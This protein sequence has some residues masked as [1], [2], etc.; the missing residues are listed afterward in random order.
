MDTFFE[1]AVETYVASVETIWLRSIHLLPILGALSPWQRTESKRLISEK[2]QAWME[3]QLHVASAPW[4]FAI[5]LQAE[6]WR[7]A[8]TPTG[9]SPLRHPLVLL[10]SELPQILAR[11]GEAAAKKALDPYRTR[12]M[13]NSRRLKK[14]LVGKTRG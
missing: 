7:A 2:R 3:S 14:R 8:F 13:S 1:G 12:S 4:A 5:R 11:A 6:L 10:S 9:I